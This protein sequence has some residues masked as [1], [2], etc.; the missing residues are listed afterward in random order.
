MIYLVLGLSIDLAVPIYIG[1]VT[2]DIS[3]NGS[4]NLLSY[5]FLVALVVGVSFWN[6]IIICLYRS[7]VWPLVTD[8]L[9][10][11]TWQT[12]SQDISAMT[13]LPLSPKKMSLSSTSL[14]SV[15][16]V[17][18]LLS[19]NTVYSWQTKWWCECDLWCHEKQLQHHSQGHCLHHSL[20][21]ILGLLEP[22][23]H[24]NPP[25]WPCYSLSL[26]W[27]IEKTNIPAQ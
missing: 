26:L 18:D 3:T 17:S 5:T 6:Y 19:N 21:R 4:K 22:Q 15:K 13:T 11:A 9:F 14:K 27:W 25:R 7:A 2:D 24:W 23:T 16:S 20:S 8:Q 10:S 1:F 12:I